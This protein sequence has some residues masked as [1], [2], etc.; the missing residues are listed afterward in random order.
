MDA[1]MHVAPR[2]VSEATT[3]NMT[4]TNVTTVGTVASI[5]AAAGGT[6]IC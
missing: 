2:A 1:C 6:T 5:A 4:T 3:A